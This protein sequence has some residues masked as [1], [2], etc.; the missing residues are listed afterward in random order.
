[1][2]TITVRQRD[3]ETFEVAVSPPLTEHVVRVRPEQ[4]ARLTGGGVGVE[5]LVEASFE[6]L[7]AREPNASILRRFDLAEIQGYFPDYERTIAAT[8]A[9]GG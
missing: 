7:L 2:Q 5:R 8:L 3:A 1:M 6:F 4:A 9:S